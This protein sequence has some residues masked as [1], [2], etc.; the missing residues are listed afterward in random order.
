MQRLTGNICISACVSLPQYLTVHDDSPSSEDA[1]VLQI[2]IEIGELRSEAEELRAQVLTLQADRDAIATEKK[3]ME[4]TSYLKSADSAI[5]SFIYFN[6][7]VIKMNNIEKI[8]AQEG[9]IEELEIAIEDCQSE[10]DRLKEVRLSCYYDM[11]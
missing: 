10:N 3:K 9:L 1:N 2:S 4:V 6:F 8:R 5:F 7:S 11:I